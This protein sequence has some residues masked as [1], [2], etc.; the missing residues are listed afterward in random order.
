MLFNAN[1]ALNLGITFGNSLFDKFFK[2]ELVICYT[3]PRFAYF[4]S[5]IFKLEI[6][7]VL[8]YY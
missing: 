8:T 4:C 7:F 2:S 3:T 5:V 6:K 1:L